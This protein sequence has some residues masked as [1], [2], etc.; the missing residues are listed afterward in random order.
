[1][2]ENALTALGGV[3]D[4]RAGAKKRIGRRALPGIATILNRPARL[5]GRIKALVAAKAAS[6]ARL[7]SLLRPILKRRRFDKILFLKVNWS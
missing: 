4:Y 7:L 5:P 6:V 1:V 2:R 3:P